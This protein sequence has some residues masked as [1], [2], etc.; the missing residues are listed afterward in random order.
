M[1]GF[2]SWVMDYITFENTRIVT[3]PPVGA[4]QQVSLRYVNTDLA[5][6]LGGEAYVD[7]VPDEMVSPFMTLRYVDGR[8][9][10]RNGDF[11][12]TN[13]SS[14]VASVKDFNN[15]RGFYSGLVGGDSEALPA[16]SPLET[17]VG[18]R[19]NDTSPAKSWSTELSRESLPLRIVLQPVCWKRQLPDSQCG[20]CARCSAR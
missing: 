17:R 11:A 7:L 16:I 1:R 12:T 6:L 15:V 4:V 5:T 2:H 10:T 9:R 19:F 18:L 20:I 3:G 14:N 8:D 13:G